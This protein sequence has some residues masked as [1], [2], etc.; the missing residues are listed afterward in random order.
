M[1]I[2]GQSTWDINVDIKCSITKEPNEE[3]VYEEETRKRKRQKPS[4]AYPAVLGEGETRYNQLYEYNVDLQSGS[5]PAG[6]QVRVCWVQLVSRH[7]RKV[8]WI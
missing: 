6:I 4:T 7:Q 8:H 3:S 5:N 1:F 2:K